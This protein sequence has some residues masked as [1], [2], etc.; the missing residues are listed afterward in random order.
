[1]T[2]VFAFE[3]F[4]DQD[5]FLFLRDERKLT[6]S[7]LHSY[8]QGAVVTSVL[9]KRRAVV[10]MVDE[11]PRSTHH[12]LRDQMQVIL[13]TS[14]LELRMREDRYLIIVKPELEEC[15]LRSMKVVNS[16]RS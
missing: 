9:T 8:G 10:G 16:G 7:G 6:V 11:D 14:S 3:C 5:V 2:T 13:S 1:V 15:F 4:A 12:R